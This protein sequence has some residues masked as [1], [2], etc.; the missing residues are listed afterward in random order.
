MSA[1]YDLGSGALYRDN[2]DGTYTLL[3]GDVSGEQGSA[4]NTS[5]QDLDTTLATQG[6]GTIGENTVFDVGENVA[7]GGGLSGVYKGSILINGVEYLAV[8]NTAGVNTVYLV[9]SLSAADAEYPALVTDGS[10]DVDPLPV[11][12]AVGTLIAT[13]GGETPV[14]T[15]QIGDRV[16]TCDGRAVPVRWVGRQTLHKLFT[17]PERLAPVRVR[18]SALAEGVPHTDLVLTADH[19]LIL[20]GLAINAGALVNGTTIAFDSM[21]S[22]PE[23]VTY[24]HVETEQHE[25]I[26]ANG[27]AAET[28]VDYV[29]RRIFDNYAEY[30]DLYGEERTITE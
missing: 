12:F 24:Y 11:C 19:A 2:N 9:T 25:V 3:T 4:L 16:L 13:P 27:A 21:D 26:L 29:Q 10:I 6:G 8:T 1:E 14:E 28:Y 22:L 17:P 18:E 5:P 15:L 23:R 30:L 20:E 7:T